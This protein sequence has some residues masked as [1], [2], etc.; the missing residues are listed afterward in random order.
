M[1][2]GQGSGGVAV[3]GGPS[4]RINLGFERFF[5]RTVGIVGTEEVGMDCSCARAKSSGDI[6][7]EIITWFA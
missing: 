4:V 2:F 5:E 6:D 1:R 7:P 3:E